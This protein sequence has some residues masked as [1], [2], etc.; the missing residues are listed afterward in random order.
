M[1]MN[2]LYLKIKEKIKAHFSMEDLEE[3]CI[4]LMLIGCLAPAFLNLLDAKR[5]PIF[6]FFYIL[7]FC[8]V[9][10]ALS[11]GNYKKREINIQELKAKKYFESS[12]KDIYFLLIFIIM[13]IAVSF[14]LDK[15]NIAAMILPFVGVYIS[16]L[17]IQGAL[18]KENEQLEREKTEAELIALKAQVNPHFLFNTLNSIYGFTVEESPKSAQS[19]YQLSE[20]MRY[21]LEKSSAERVNM[22]DEIKFLENYVALQQ[23]RIPTQENIDL[24]LRIN[25]D[26]K[27][28]EI[29]PLLL[30]PIVE[31]AFKYGISIDNECF[32]HIDLRISN[33]KL[34]FECKNKKL[35]ERLLEQG[36]GTGLEHLQKRLNLTYPNRHVFEIIKLDSVFIIKLEI[37]LNHA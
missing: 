20:I 36:A 30:T 37:E 10:S 32:I 19:I 21:T 12:K 13:T 17:R 14:S 23:L 4:W 18:F 6:V 11:I 25:Y 31:N 24:Q 3:L 9:A 2:N 27:P 33:D 7:G 35:S 16:T 8:V 28:Y 22:L 1:I 34:Y 29:A 5:S 26:E 15:T